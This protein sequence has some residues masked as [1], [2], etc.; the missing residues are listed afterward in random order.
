MT[1][2]RSTQ[3]SLQDTAHYH[4]ISRCVRRAFLCGE[5]AYS[6]KSFEHR[7]LWLVERMRLLSQVF[8]ID[9]CAYAIMSNHYHLVLHVNTA[10]A[11]SWSHQEVAQ[12]WTTL[13]KAPLLVSRW[14][15]CELKSKAE[16]NKTLALIGEWRERLTDISWFMRN[17][18]EF[19]AREA[20]KEEG[21]KGR[22]WEGRFKSQALLDEK[23]LLSCMAYVDLNP[24]RAD[25]AQS[26]ED[27]EFT[28]IYERIHSIACQG[29]AGRGEVTSLPAKGLVGFLGNEREVRPSVFSKMGGIEFSLLDYLA[30]VEE[31]G[32]VVRPNKRGYISPCSDTILGRLNMSAEEWLTLSESFGGKFRCA[33]G[34]TKELESYALHTNRAWVAGK[35]SMMSS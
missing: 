23:A 20:N 14:L 34:T 33:V 18:N 21:C 17:L 5:D 9:V 19:V 24:V 22:F 2:A 15:G 7:R 4:C 12:R 35:C 11:E 26:L 32:Q 29:D 6:G 27:S 31:L 1:Q 16:I 13:Y 30:L 28:S 10:L 3:V 25:M 8:A